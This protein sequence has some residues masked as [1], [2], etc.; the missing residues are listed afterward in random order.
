M[1]IDSDTFPFPLPP[2]IPLRKPNAKPV[3]DLKDAK[4]STFTPL[5]PGLVPF[6]GELLRKILQLKFTDYNF[7]DRNKYP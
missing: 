7:N 1:E 3:K 5:F 4:F 2:Y 6:T